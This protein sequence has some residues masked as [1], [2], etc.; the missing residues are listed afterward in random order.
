MRALQPKGAHD[1]GANALQPIA[2]DFLEQEPRWGAPKSDPRAPEG[3]A[4]VQPS[5]VR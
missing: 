1:S 5:V 2:G 3:T 4:L